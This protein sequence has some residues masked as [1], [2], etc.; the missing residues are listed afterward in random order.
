[1][2][3]VQQA[4]YA[5]DEEYLLEFRADNSGC[6]KSGITFDVIVSWNSLDELNENIKEMNRGKRTD[7]SPQ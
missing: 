1:M 2:R 7:R 4:H 6:I 3:D 5:G